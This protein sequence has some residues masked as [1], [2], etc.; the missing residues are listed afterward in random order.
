[1]TPGNIQLKV[2]VR[3]GPCASAGA[4]CIPGAHGQHC[5]AF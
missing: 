5:E 2:I 1:M 3:E 4:Q